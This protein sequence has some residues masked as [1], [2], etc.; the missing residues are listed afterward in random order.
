MQKPPLLQ[1]VRNSHRNAY[2]A[3]KLGDTK[4]SLSEPFMFNLV[5]TF[6]TSDFNFHTYPVSHV[7][8]ID[9]SCTATL[10]ELRLKC[11]T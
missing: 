11:K 3:G 7:A 5:Q 6:H 2:T 10:A 9:G 4:K 8:V 1:A